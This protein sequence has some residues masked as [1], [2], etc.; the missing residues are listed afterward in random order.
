MCGAPRRAA[1]NLYYARVDDFRRATPPGVVDKVPC[2]Y[3][4]K[5]HEARDECRPD[6]YDAQ[7]NLCYWQSLSSALPRE[8]L[9]FQVGTSL[10]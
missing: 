4:I 9:R 1:N 8:Y 7:F 2:E 6:N 10:T 3:I 5:I